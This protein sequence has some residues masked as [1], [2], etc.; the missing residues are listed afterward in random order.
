MGGYLKI[1]IAA[2]LWGSLGTIIRYIDVPIPVMV[3]LRVAFAAVAI[4]IFILVQGKLRELAVGR[5][6]LPI[7]VMGALL[8]LNWTAFFLSVNLTSVANAVLLTYTAPIFVAVL[9]PF[10][11]KEPLERVTVITLGVSLVGAALIAAPSLTGFGASSSAG[12]F[13]AIVSALSYAAIVLVSKPLASRVNILAM[14]FYQEIFS[15]LVLLPFAFFYDFTLDPRTLLLIAVIGIVHTAFAS[16]I[17][18]SGLRT[19]KAQ[20]V[21]IFTYLDP[22]SAVVFAAIF[23]GEVPGLSTIIGG[24]LIILSGLALVVTTQRR[25]EAEV[26]A[27]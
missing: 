26:V 19:T 22:V 4:F 8:S 11:L 20:H 15:A 24:M 17:Y 3:L 2:I 7:A 25:I 21:G 5:D 12:L 23:L 13:W 18:L 1:S 16:A 9:A 14:I 27:E 10:V 6:I